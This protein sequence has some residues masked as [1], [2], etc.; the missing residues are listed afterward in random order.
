MRRIYQTQHGARAGN[1]FASCVAT[2]LHLDLDKV[3]HFCA[4][5]SDWYLRFQKWLHARQLMVVSVDLK[6]DENSRNFLSRVDGGHWIAS[7]PNARDGIMHSVIYAGD[8]L[9]HDPHVSQEGLRT[10]YSAEF[11]VPCHGEIYGLKKI[12]LPVTPAEGGPTEMEIEAPR[13]TSDDVRA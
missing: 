2:L 5:G 9:A 6:G 11:L 12:E 13:E 4:Y 3:P 10:I 7:G 8:K 1:C